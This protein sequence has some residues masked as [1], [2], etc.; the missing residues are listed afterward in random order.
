M[1]RVFG[2]L[3]LVALV[4]TAAADPALWKGTVT[5][6][7]GRTGRVTVKGLV[8]PFAV[9]ATG[10]WKCRGRG[11]PVKRGTLTAECRGYYDL[12]DNVY[13]EV[14]GTIVSPSGSIV[15]FEGDCDRLLSLGPGEWYVGVNE[16]TFQVPRVR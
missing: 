14:T 5:D 6:A 13:F 8:D 16:G 12:F 15:E 4:G 2:V 10:K 11:C 9:E 3:T 7:R 1:R